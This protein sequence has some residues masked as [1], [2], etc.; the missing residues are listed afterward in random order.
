[1]APISSPPVDP[2]EPVEPVEPFDP[3]DPVIAKIG[4]FATKIVQK[5]KIAGLSIGVMKAGKVIVAKGYG[6]SDVENEVAAMPETVYCIASITKQ[7]TAASILGLVAAG[8]IGLEDDLSKY[9][10]EFDTQKHKVTIRQLLN[11]TSGIP[12]YTTLGDEV[13]TNRSLKFSHEDLLAMIKGVQFDFEPGTNWRYNNSGYYL[14]GMIIERVSGKSYA[15]FIEEDLALPMGLKHTKYCWNAPGI[16]HRSRGYRR[17]KS[18][19][20]HNASYASMTQPY[21]AGALCSTIGDLMSWTYALHHGK[22]VPAELYKEMISPSILRDA[23]QIDYGFGLH[24]GDYEGHREL[25]HGGTI[26][27]FSAQ[28]SAYPD[29]ELVVVLL[30]NT[31]GV[32]TKLAQMVAHAAFEKDEQMKS[33]REE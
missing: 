32:Y 28:L 21:A 10:P 14:L 22:V 19:G 20:F 23:K 27:G 6:M 29:D 12:S 7:F 1:V 15:D 9:V 26:D 24:I 16:A 11:H 3:V 18:D 31:E 30:A 33:A 13:K 2:V 5:G 4:A 17:S 8:R 25:S